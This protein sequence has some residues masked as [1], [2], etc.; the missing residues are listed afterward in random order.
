AAEGI[1][2]VVDGLISSAGATVALAIAPGVRRS[3]IASH[4]SAEPG[5]AAALEYLR[6][7]PLMDLGTRLGEGS[8][9]ALGISLCVA[10]CRLLDEMATFEEAG[11]SDS[12]DAVEPEQ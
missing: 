3:L 7:E 4:R 9:A 8:G 5:H 1:P 11:V 10:A 6:L 12:D 2:A